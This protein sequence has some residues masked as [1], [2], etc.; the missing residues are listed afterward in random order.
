MSDATGTRKNLEIEVLRG[1]AVLLAIATHL[2]V[3][4]PYHKDALGQ[5]YLT[6]IM[7]A[8][9]VDL[10]FGISG[11]VVSKSFLEFF[12]RLAGQ[13]RFLLAFQTFWIRRACRLLPTSWLW[14]WIVFF[15]SIGFNTTGL[16]ATPWDSLRSFL[17]VV[18]MSGNIANQFGPM[19][20]PNDVYWSL[21]LEEQFY[22]AFPFFLL[23][24]SAP[25]RW[26]VL[27]VAIG[28]QFFLDRNYNI[29]FTHP[30]AAFLWSTRLDSLMWGVVIFLF[31]R[32]EYYRRVE[33][34]FL[35]R[36]PLLRSLVSVALLYLLIALPVK[37]LHWPVT[38]GLV[39]LTTAA[40]VFLASYDR[41]YSE[42]IPP[43]SRFLAWVGARSY[44]VYIIHMTAY[45]MTVEGWTRYSLERGAPLSASDTLPMLLTATVLL[46]GFAELNYRFVEAPLR[47]KG[48]R[49]AE[50]RLAR[51]NVPA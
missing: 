26:R 51:A 36:I 16:F 23:A 29:V 1:V 25:W 34:A 15:L 18:T 33:P 28:V 20:Y 46:F 2:P 49:I 32:T 27:L 40:L 17:V 42:P 43:L 35:A 12:D 4:L 10:F 41:G 5:V 47:D 21:A 13:G 39:A 24:V 48:K 7:P 9:G 19:L 37:F 22:L 11:F 3:L 50:A 38:M 44:A 8:S 45:R 30:L 6:Q 31:S 14:V